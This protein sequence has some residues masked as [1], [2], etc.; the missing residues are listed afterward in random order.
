MEFETA[1]LRFSYSSFV[2]PGIVYDYD[3]EK[4]SRVELKRIVVPGGFDP[5]QYVSERIYAIGAD[6]TRI[7]ISLIHRKDVTPDGTRPTF[8]YVY[9]A[10]G[11]PMSP[12][13]STSIISMLDRG[14]VYALA[15]VR[16]GGDQGREWHQGGRLAT[17]TN[18]FT[19]T[20]AAAEAL[21]SAGWTRPQ[22]LALEGRSAGGLTL[23]AAL[24]LRPDLYRVAHLGVPFVDVINTM[25]DP[26]VPLTTGEYREWGNPNEPEAFR[27]ILA[28]SPYDNLG[29][30][31]YPAL[32]VTT[33][34]NDMQVRYSEPTK[35]VA[36]LRALNPDAHVIMRVNMGVGHG[37]ASGRYKALDERAQELAYLLWML[38]YRK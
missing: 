10:Y 36:K 23:G 25:L 5:D 19:D 22:L 26:T 17:K 18:T 4:R 7:P 34:I 11:I 28:Y 37:G 29:A 14:M 16:G 9:G 13:Y 27:R 12:T 32:L 24:N 1:T 20:N 33:G 2:T 3:M 21:I 38:G 15:H 30:M 31:P 35:Y 8:L 6:G